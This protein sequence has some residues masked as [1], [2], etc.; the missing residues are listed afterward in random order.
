MKFD[1]FVLFRVNNFFYI[2]KFVILKILNE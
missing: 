1:T 2:D